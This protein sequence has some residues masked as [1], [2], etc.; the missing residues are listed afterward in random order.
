MSA[1][2]EEFVSFPPTHGVCTLLTFLSSI[3]WSRSFKF[4][5]GPDEVPI[6]VHEKAI[7]N[8]STALSTLM[9]GK[10]SEGTA[11]AATW[12]DV[13]E[14][15]FLRFSQFAYT[16]DYSVPKMIVS[17]ELLRKTVKTHPK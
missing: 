6:V 1:S 7:A 10:M 8:Q 17:N 13:D 2:F 15:T 4:L 14:E 9:R 3:F 11:G 5:V 16:G 12:K